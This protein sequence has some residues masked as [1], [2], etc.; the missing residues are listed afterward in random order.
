MTTF[1]GESL[2]IR[3]ASVNYHQIVADML[4]QTGFDGCSSLKSQCGPADFSKGYSYCFEGNQCPLNGLSMT[5]FPGGG[6]GID[7]RTDIFG[8]GNGTWKID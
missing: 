8:V 2:C 7:K 4:Y 5:P 6:Q 3:R 1:N